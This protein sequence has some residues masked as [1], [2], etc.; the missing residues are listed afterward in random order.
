MNADN[1]EWQKALELLQKDDLI[2]PLALH[3][4]TKQKLDDMGKR[5]GMTREEVIIYCIH[6]GINA[7]DIEDWYI[8]R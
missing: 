2:I 6:Q 5:K 8:G 3:K 7:E 1:T 4:I